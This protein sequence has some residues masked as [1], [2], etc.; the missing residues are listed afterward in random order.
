MHD[1]KRES[2]IQEMSKYTNEDHEIWG[3]LFD[4]QI[5]NLK[6]KVCREYFDS[7]DTL[8]ETLNNSAIPDFKN[9]DKIL[10]DRT[11]W[12]IEVVPGLIEV[13]P[14]FTLLAAKRFC[15]STWIR[16]RSQLD[17]LEEPDMFHDTFGH[18]PLLVHPQYAEAMRLIGELG[19]KYIDN[20]DAIIRLKRLYWFTIEF[21]LIKGADKVE[22]YGAGIISSSGETKHI[23]ESEGVEVIPFDIKTI[24]NTPFNN[25]EIQW[26]YFEL[27]SMDQLYRE[28]A[29]LVEEPN[30]LIEGE[31]VM[32]SS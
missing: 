24:F 9:V 12:S 7:L 15:S 20:S 32:A 13:E 8:S 5:V 31:L 25:D 30:V 26:K 10:L 17:Y 3:I 22:I 6:D 29:K 1:F 18:I 28:V 21:G 4:R 23:Y 14:F 11:G 2:M 27:E 16:K 19:V